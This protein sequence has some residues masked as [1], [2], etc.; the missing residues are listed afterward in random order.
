MFNLIFIINLRE[1]VPNIIYYGFAAM[2]K[3][4]FKKF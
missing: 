4:D 2:Y 1:L 3:T